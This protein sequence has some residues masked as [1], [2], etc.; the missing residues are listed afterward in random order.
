MDQWISSMGVGATEVFFVLE[1]R[2]KVAR[3][4]F[5]AVK[6]SDSYSSS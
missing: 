5:I 6:E 2:K 3:R 4:K 1:Q